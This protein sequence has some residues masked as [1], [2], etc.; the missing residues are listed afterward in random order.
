MITDKTPDKLLEKRGVN[1]VI[2]RSKIKSK[3]KD[4][5]RHFTL[6]KTMIIGVQNDSYHISTKI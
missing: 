6:E 2:F 4:L 1:W 5:G 3:T